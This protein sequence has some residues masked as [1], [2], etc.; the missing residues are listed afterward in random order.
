MQDP[1]TRRKFG[2]GKKPGNKLTEKQSRF[3][4]EYVRDMNATRAS[5]AAGYGTSPNA[6][7]GMLLLRKEHVRKAIASRLKARSQ[8]LQVDSNWVLK[9]AVR[10]FQELR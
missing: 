6:N 5:R 3:V 4:D 1:V 2:S 10:M 8:R 9:E 7:H